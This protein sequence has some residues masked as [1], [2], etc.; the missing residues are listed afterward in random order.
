MRLPAA[1][2]HEILTQI[3]ISLLSSDPKQFHQRKFDLFMTWIAALLSWRS[4]EDRVNIVCIATHRIQQ[5][6]FARGLEVSHCR[7]DKVT[8]TV[9][10]MPITQ[11]RPAL[12]RLN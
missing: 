4:A 1:L 2:I 7:L 6:A 12:L 5:N 3:Q 10:L 11:V 9:R 8:S